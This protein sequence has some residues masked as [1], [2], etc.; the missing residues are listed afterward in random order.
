MEEL[1]EKETNKDVLFR[2]PKYFMVNYYFCKKTV[3]ISEKW[4]MLMMMIGMELITENRRL[5]RPVKTGLLALN[6]N[7]EDQKKKHYTYTK[8]F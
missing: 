6:T 8:M 7:L 4:E 3:I 1:L 2:K 5:R